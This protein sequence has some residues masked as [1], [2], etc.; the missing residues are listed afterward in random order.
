MLHNGIIRHSSSP[1]NVPVILVK[2]KRR[3][4]F[5]VSCAI[6]GGVND[7]I[8]KDSYPLPH[9]HDVFDKMHGAQFWTTLDATSAYWPM[10]LAEE[11]K[12]KT[13]FSVPRGKYEFNVTP[14]CLCN[15]GA[16]HT[17]V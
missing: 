3:M 5:C 4:V 11:D 12:A 8:R 17:S 2:K 1:K 9:I 10:P 14:F 6:L 16:S 13:T 15:A 7:V